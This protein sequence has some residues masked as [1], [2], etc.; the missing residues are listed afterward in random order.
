MSNFSLVGRGRM[1]YIMYEQYANKNIVYFD[2]KSLH[3]WISNKGN[4]NLFL[5]KLYE[6]CGIVRDSPATE[7]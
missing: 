1:S 2:D 6:A 5:L 3:N 4:K 7:E